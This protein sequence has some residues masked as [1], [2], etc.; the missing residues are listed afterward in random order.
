MPE[1]EKLASK[2]NDR[3]RETGKTVGSHGTD[4]SDL[5]L[6]SLYEVADDKLKL[7]MEYVALATAISV[8]FH[9]RRMLKDMLVECQL[10]FS[11]AR[12]LSRY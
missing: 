11:T 10:L 9:V 8:V 7:C 3:R 4:Y 12:A 5:T 6:R 1:K 2:A